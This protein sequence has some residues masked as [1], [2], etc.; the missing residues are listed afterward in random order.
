MDASVLLHRKINGNNT[1]LMGIYVVFLLALA[2]G[3]A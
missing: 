3:V 1:N 2:P